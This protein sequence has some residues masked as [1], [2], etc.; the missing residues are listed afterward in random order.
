MT[1]RYVVMAGS[2]SE[3]IFYAKAQPWVSINFQDVFIWKSLSL[4]QF[5]ADDR[6]AMLNERLRQIVPIQWRVE[7]L[8]DIREWYV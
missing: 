1:E 4:A 8:E 3:P 5:C 2:I 7:R 6:N